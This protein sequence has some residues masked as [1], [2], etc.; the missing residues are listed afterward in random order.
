[1]TALQWKGG[2]CVRNKCIGRVSIDENFVVSFGMQVHG[3]NC[4]GW[5][6]ILHVGHENMERSPGFWLHPKSYKLHVRLSDTNNKNTGYDPNMVLEKD[7]FY[8][9]KLQCINNQVSLFI[10]DTMQQFSAGIYHVTRYKCP[11]FV[12]DPWHS[13]ANVTITDLEIFAPSI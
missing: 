9:I 2:K 8:Q 12:S 6:S 5:E 7:T 10:N 13:A 3:K 4:D 1:M 11:V